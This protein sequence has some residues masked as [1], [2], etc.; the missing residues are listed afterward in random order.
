MDEPPLKKTRSDPSEPSQQQITS[1]RPTPAPAEMEESKADGRASA[2]SHNQTWVTAGEFTANSK[3]TPDRAD[4]EDTTAVDSA[5]ASSQDFDPA[6][7]IPRSIVD[8]DGSPRL[9]PRQI[10]ECPGFIASLPDKWEKH[11]L[12][13]AQ[14]RDQD[15]DDSWINIRLYDP[16]E[17]AEHGNHYTAPILPF[18]DRF[19]FE[20]GVHP[21]S[22]R[23][24]VKEPVKADRSSN[25]SDGA[26]S[27]AESR[28]NS[29]PPSEGS[30]GSD[31]VPLLS[32]SPD[33]ASA[34]VETELNALAQ[35]DDLASEWHKSLQGIHKDT[36]E[37][38]LNTNK[39]SQSS[40]D[41][42]G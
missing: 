17:F 10:S 40:P 42:T 30:V 33:R 27:I 3:S 7:F 8:A 28:E 41:K 32:S 18:G 13:V 39:V 16:A 20:F 35:H 26:H 4:S 24:T 15:Q 5:Y 1:D 31:R 12:A 37:L 11:E 38:L 19:F 36:D 25:S 29:A 21:S 23:K 2:D 34:Q 14:N 6:V 9:K 22:A